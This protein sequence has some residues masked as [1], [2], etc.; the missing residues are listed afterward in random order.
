MVTSTILNFIYPP[1]PSVFMTAASVM[2]V[3]SLAILGLLEAGGVHL[4]NSEFTFT[5]YKKVPSRTVMLLLYLPAFLAGLASFLIFPDGDLRSLILR[6][7]ISL[8]FF[9][10]I[11]EVLLVHKFSGR[12]GVN[13]MV[14]ISLA[15]FLSTVTSIY[16]Q[17]LTQGLPEP[18][19]DLLYPGIALFLIGITGNLYH[20]ILLSKLRKEGQREYKIPKGGLF[21]WVICPHY[22]FEVMVF[23]GISFI[24]QSIYSCSWFLATFFYLLGRSYATRRWYTSKFEDFPEDVKALIPYI[25]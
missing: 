20:H 19:V 12:M 8:H 15:Y 21:G 16:S 7:A 6:S 10:R 14:V 2:I 9:K 17:H 23:V 24:S 3:A 4:Q 13:S 22:L 1:P 5:P 25:F 11:L 18:P